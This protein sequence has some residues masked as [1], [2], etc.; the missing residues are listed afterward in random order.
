MGTGLRNIV[1]SYKGRKL[2]DGKGIG[3]KGWLTKKRIDSFQVYYGRAIREN[4]GNVEEAQKAV[5]AI[6]YH[7]LSTDNTPCHEYCPVGEKSWCGW[8]KD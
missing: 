1:T 8:Q 2:P 3:G 4:K 5:K 7:S 6:L